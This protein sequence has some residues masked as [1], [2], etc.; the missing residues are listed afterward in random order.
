[1]HKISFAATF[2]WAPA[3]GGQSRLEKL[4]E[5][6]GF[7][8][9]G[10]ELREQVEGFLYWVILRTEEAILLRQS[11]PIQVASA[12]GEAIGLLTGITLPQ[13]MELKPGCLLQLETYFNN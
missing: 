2:P 13:P 6:L 10:R 8:A 7:V 9:L 4:E 11:I 1:M 12:W 3:E 5:S